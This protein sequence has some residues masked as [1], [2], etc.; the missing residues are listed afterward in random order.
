[1]LKPKIAQ[2]L[3]NS[4]SEIY[5]PV[6]HFLEHYEKH[7]LQFLA[8]RPYPVD[9]SRAK[10]TIDDRSEREPIKGIH[11]KLRSIARALDRVLSSSPWFPK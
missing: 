8:V 3:I 2:S 7:G 1:L 5:E 6:D 4:S 11:K 10:S 9:I